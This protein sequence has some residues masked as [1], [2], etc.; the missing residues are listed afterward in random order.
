MKSACLLVAIAL[1]HSASST[2]AMDQR[3]AKIVNREILLMVSSDPFLRTKVFP[4]IVEKHPK[5]VLTIRDLLQGKNYDPNAIEYQAGGFLVHWAAKRRKYSLLTA[6]L[7]IPGISCD[8]PF[9]KHCTESGAAMIFLEAGVNP[10][11]LTDDQGNTVLHKIATS[12]LPCDDLVEPYIEAG[13]PVDRKNNDGDSAL[14]L[15]ALHG[16]IPLLWWLISEG[17]FINELDHKKRTPLHLAV[18]GQYLWVVQRLLQAGAYVGACDSSNK[19]ALK[20]AVLTDQNKS[21]RIIAQLA[22]ACEEGDIY[23]SQNLRRQMCE[24]GIEANTSA[25]K[26]TLK[27]K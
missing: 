2:V 26:I 3:W 11:K 19:M 10:Q 24:L 9:F 1:I 12:L 6:L 20:R 7:Q 5:F 4:V 16:K 15:A 14:H 23:I 21:Q 17:A 18:K 25:Y 27:R 13:V 8:I 22:T